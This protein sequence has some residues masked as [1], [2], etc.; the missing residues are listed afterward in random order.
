MV[1]SRLFLA[2]A[3]LASL[4]CVSLHAQETRRDT[5]EASR[6][7]AVKRGL[8]G[9]RLVKPSEIRTLTTPLGDGSAIKLI[10]TLP[11][12]A[13]G[14]EGSSAIY[15]RGGNLGGNVI[16]I[17]GVPLYG[18]GHILG[19]STSYSPDIAADTRFMVGGFSSEE[20][21]L[22][23]S[24]IKVS[25]RDGDFTRISGGVS[26]SPFIAGGFLSAPLV[27]DRVSLFAAA[28][29]SPVGPELR[30]V[31]T[32]TT[33]MDSVS[34][35]KARVWDA[36][37]KVKW[38]ITQ[39]QSLALSGFASGDNY[40]YN[41]GMNSEDRMGWDNTVGSL[42]HEVC[43]G[44]AWRVETGL[45]INRFHNSQEMRKTLGRNENHIGLESGLREQ[46]AMS[47]VFWNGRAGW[48]AQAGL[49]ARK[50][51]FDMDVSSTML[52]AHTQVGKSKENKY[53]IMAAGRI[54]RFFSNKEKS[55][56]EN[57]SSFDPEVSFSGRLFVT[58]W[59]GIEATF[60]KTV[61]YYHTLEGIPLG[62]SMDMIVPSDARLA[63]E[64]ASQVYAGL[65]LSREGHN[66]S[67]GA[68]TKTM[69]NLVFFEDATQLFSQAA[70]GWKD[71]I[72]MGYGTSKGVEIL[73]EY[74]HDKMAARIAYTLSKTDR[75]FPKLN[76]GI[77][78]PAKFDRRHILNARIEYILSKKES[79]ELGINTFFTYQSGHWATVP[80]GQFSGWI[81]PGDEEVII[82]YHTTLHNWQ[83]PPYVRWDVG[84]F[85]RYGKG[86]RR[87]GTLN[88]GI[89]NLL[90]RHNIYSI[91]FD[92]ND[93]RWKSLSIFPI[94]PTI[95]WTMEF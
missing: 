52:T 34:A 5:I 57:L 81:V 74:N 49:K 26:A 73:Y 7:T 84:A 36:F 87:P 65:F 95:S 66:I 63:P 69:D 31:K 68:Y 78:F 88:A 4:S 85:W 56:Y 6:V 50:A 90:N 60:D 15:V 22:T 16:T 55:S 29:V 80:A 41:Y 35:I 94:M 43:F 86:T 51:S 67:A 37:A 19:F 39:R 47:S 11:G 91:T 44:T 12:V 92:P 71:N 28:R 45:S 40:A 58:G 93:R 83:T 21:N 20:G 33:A 2:M 10:Q 9:S 62:W 24:H 27:K 89:Y 30:A 1:R 53:E 38:R 76:D 13:T 17:D 14:A 48:S 64:K 82:D 42:L 23:S 46:T 3:A 59:A 32:L 61:Q 77:P 8:T 54:N 79:K 18:S 25:T 72:K 70:A 75:T